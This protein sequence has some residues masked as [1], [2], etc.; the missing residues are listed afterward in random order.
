MDSV[1]LRHHQ[2]EREFYTS[3]SIDP[4]PFVPVVF[5][6]F[7]TSSLALYHTLPAGQHRKVRKR[8]VISSEIQVQRLY[9]T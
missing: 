3:L 4:L 7:S 8:L 2:K 1:L 6:C 5:F 9:Q